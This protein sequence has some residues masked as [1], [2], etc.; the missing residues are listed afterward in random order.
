MKV[1]Q[2]LLKLNQEV[3]EHLRGYKVPEKPPVIAEAVIDDQETEV[4][5][6]PQEFPTTEEIAAVT[7]APK[8]EA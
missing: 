8:T 5:N 6:Y 2:N 4:G 1:L 7:T 3:Q